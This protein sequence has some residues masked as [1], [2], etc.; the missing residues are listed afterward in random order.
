MNHFELNISLAELVTQ[1]PET[2]RVL[3]SNRLDFCCHGEIGFDVACVNK[4][5]NPHSLRGELNVEIDSRRDQQDRPNLDG[6][7]LTELLQY[8]V[9][10]HHAYLRKVMPYL[11]T[12]CQKVANVHGQNEPKLLELRY[13]FEEL[14]QQIEPH[15]IEE[16]EELFPLLLSANPQSAIAHALDGMIEEHRSV[17]KLLEKIR[18]LTDGYHPPIGACRSFSTLYAELDA[19]EDDLL[20]HIHIENHILAKRVLNSFE[21]ETT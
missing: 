17:G 4:G 8:I 19:L 6:I 5:I 15:L 14:K 16:E 20:N 21:L 1:F 10:K 2:S 12:L 9:Q 18:H 3:K 11:S 13:V 7:P